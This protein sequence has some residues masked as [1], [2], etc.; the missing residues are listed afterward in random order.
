MKLPQQKPVM[1]PTA[2]K[3]PAKP[4]S[5]R[6][7]PQKLDSQQ[8]K[9]KPKA[10]PQISAAEKPMPQ[11]SDP[12]TSNPSKPPALIPQ[13]QTLSTPS[14]PSSTPKPRKPHKHALPPPSAPKNAQQAPTQHANSASGY[15]HRYS[16]PTLLS[17]QRSAPNLNSCL[18]ESMAH[19]DIQPRVCNA[20]SLPENRKVC[21]TCYST[22]AARLTELRDILSTLQQY[23]EMSSKGMIDAPNFHLLT[24]EPLE[25]TGEGNLI[26]TLPE[27]E[28]DLLDFSD[29]DLPTSGTQSFVDALSSHESSTGPED[30]VS[31]LSEQNM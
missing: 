3:K 15:Q 25:P 22:I 21:K 11:K 19:E 26:S 29:D 12:Q 5:I 10:K 17:L 16:I 7:E 14:T 30:R 13:N 28:G 9:P 24:G 20:P 4:P 8:P 23:E 6:P 2:P 18:D 27:T 31:A 1:V